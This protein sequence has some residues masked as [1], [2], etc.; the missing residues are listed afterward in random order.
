MHS[1]DW[2]KLFSQSIPLLLHGL[3]LLLGAGL[4]VRNAHSQ[5][6]RTVLIGLGLAMLAVNLAV[7]WFGFHFAVDAVEQATGSMGMAMLVFQIVT[8]LPWAV[9]LLLIIWAGFYGDNRQRYEVDT[10]EDDAK[11]SQ[12]PTQ[13]N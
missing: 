13:H 2:F 7:S 6:R 12:L 3:P 4:C 8:G 1:P 11:T 9:A 10:F 5:P